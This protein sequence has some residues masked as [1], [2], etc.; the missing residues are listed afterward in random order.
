MSVIERWLLQKMAMVNAMPSAK[1]KSSEWR[2]SRIR[3]IQSRCTELGI[4]AKRKEYMKK[5][6]NKDSL[7]LLSDDDVE[8]VYRWVM[9]QKN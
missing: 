5:T 7:T 3:A 1:K 2:A 9:S 8:K 4:Q 6:F